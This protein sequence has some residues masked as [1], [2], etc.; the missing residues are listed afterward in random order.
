MMIQVLSPKVTPTDTR[1]STRGWIPTI[2]PFRRSDIVPVAT[3]MME[4]TRYLITIR[5]DKNN[6]SKHEL[7]NP[8]CAEV[9]RQGSWRGIRKKKAPEMGVSD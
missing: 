6:D 5:S 1:I 2:K 4:I 8:M 9:K 3:A 7:T